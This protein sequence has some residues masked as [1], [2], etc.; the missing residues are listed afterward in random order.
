MFE[1]MFEIMDSEGEGEIDAET[2]SRVFS[3][4][5]FH[6]KETEIQSKLAE[7]DF[8][9]NG[10]LDFEEFSTAMAHN[11]FDEF[12]AENGQKIKTLPFFLTMLHY[13]RRL[14]VSEITG[15]LRQRAQASIAGGH[16]S[17]TS[18]NAFESTV[19]TIRNATQ[20]EIDLLDHVEKQREENEKEGL[21][22]F[23]SRNTTSIGY[24]DGRRKR[25][26][27]TSVQQRIL[28]GLNQSK[29]DRTMEKLELSGHDLLH[30]DA[31][32]AAPRR[33]SRGSVDAASSP[34]KKFLRM[35]PDVRP[36]R[37]APNDKELIRMYSVG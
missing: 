11:E 12:T 26:G 35:P 10:L 37:I 8:D 19:G 36:V 30:A 27:K 14:L 7:L 24:S 21:N 1:N 5:G 4:V 2:L 18:S 28:L 6:M 22:M 33:P 25:R 15:G 20:D 29:H 13:R 9:G 32:D 34:K 23:A 16:A 31:K 3:S 17:R